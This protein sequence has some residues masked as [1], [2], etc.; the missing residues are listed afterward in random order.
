M[1]AMKKLLWRFKLALITVVFFVI[2]CSKN[3]DNM[4]I[5]E[6][7]IHQPKRYADDY[8]KDD[9]RKPL[10]ILNFMNIEPGNK[11]IDLLG[12]GGYYTELF[13]YIVGESG[14]VYIQ[15]N[16]L[17]LRFSGEELDK[18]LKKGRLANV[19]RIDSEF[20]DMQLPEN[21]DVMFIGLS[22]HDIYVPRKDPV[23]MAN[24]EE[25]LSQIYKSIK[26]GG[27]L[28]IIDHAAKPGTGISTTPK[29]HRIDEEWTKKDLAK[30]GFKFFESIDALRNPN[31]N[32]EIDIWKKDVIYKT[33]RFI[34]MY[35][36]VEKQK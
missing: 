16:S 5:H 8:A 4:P 7:S 20:A 6:Q 2:G 19:S 10:A 27:K 32:L 22:Y 18:R 36:K 1:V 23:I 15:N 24:R 33:D 9:Y 14:H 12:G 29:L 34:H 35:V 13:N 11:V 25:F 31:D 21:I 26:L 30:A 17:F 3:L 28:I